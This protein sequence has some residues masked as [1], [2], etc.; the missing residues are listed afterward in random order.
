MKN[1]SAALFAGLF[2]AATHCS[3]TTAAPMDAESGL[4]SGDCDPLD[5]NIKDATG[6]QCSKDGAI[7]L[8]CGTSAPSGHLTCYV[9]LGGDVLV[10]NCVNSLVCCDMKAQCYNPAQ[11]PNF[12]LRPYCK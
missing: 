2:I 7:D 8:D 12:C 1:C 4:D 9:D 10:S 5:A 3:P 11:E 6:S